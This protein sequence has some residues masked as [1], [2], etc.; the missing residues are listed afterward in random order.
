MS[1]FTC[2]LSSVSAFVFQFLSVG[3][4]DLIIQLKRIIKEADMKRVPIFCFVFIA[5]MISSADIV[6]NSTVCFFSCFNIYVFLIQRRSV[7]VRCR[8]WAIS[9]CL[10]SSITRLT[11]RNPF[12]SL[13]IL[14]RFKLCDSRLFIFFDKNLNRSKN[15]LSSYWFWDEIEL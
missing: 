2:V 4:I 8:N 5:D 1:M 3:V 9:S 12:P 10:S 11:S 13:Q 6:Q 15:A 14:L 7:H